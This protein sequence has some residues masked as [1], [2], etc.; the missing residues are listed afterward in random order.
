MTLNIR[1][2]TLFNSIVVV[3]EHHS[4]NRLFYFALPYLNFIP[5]WNCGELSNFMKLLS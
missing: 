4:D 5:Y 3:C 2:F 1:H